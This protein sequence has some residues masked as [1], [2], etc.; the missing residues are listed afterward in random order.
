MSIRRL[1][2]QPPATSAS[3][4]TATTPAAPTATNTVKTPA[5]AARP[6]ASDQSSFTPP[7]R[8]PTELTGASA[9]QAPIPGPV[10]VNSREGQAAIQSTLA[11]ISQ[12]KSPPGA[13]LI[14]PRFDASQAFTPRSIERDE[15]GMTHVRMDRTHEGVKVF[16][17]QVIGHLDADGKFASL[18]G[19]TSSL[20]TGLGSTQPKLSEKDALAIAQKEFG[21]T[22]DQAPQVERVLYQDAKGEYQSAYRV[23]LANLGGKEQP[24]RMNYLLDANSG[25]LFESFNQL[26][27]IERPKATRTEPTAVT[28]TATPNAAIQDNK[29]VTSKIT[30]G[31][32]V[33]IDKLKLDLDIAHSY[34]GDLTVQLTSPS[35][36]TATVSDRK[37]GSADDLKGPFDLS[38]FAGEKTKGD[39]TLTVKDSAAGDTGTLKSWGLTATPKIDKPLPTPPASGTAD[40]TSLYSGKVDLSTKKN[41]DGTYSLE[42][43][44]RGQ[45]VVTLDAQG[46]DEAQNPVAIKDNNN[47]WGEAG[48]PSRNKAAV[49][50]HYGAQM[51]Y[52]MYKNVLG[53]DSLDGKGEKLVSNIH[54]GTDFVNAY[55]DGK[56]MNYGDG[57]GK[58]AGPL[59][60][61]DIAGHE[62]THG[63]TERTAGLLYRNE[64]GG[65]N[66]AFSDIMGTGVEWYAS[67]KNEAV[68]FDWAVGED[69]WTPNNGDPTDA[70]RYMDDPTKD[71]Y[72]VD[73][74]KNYPK[75]T[76]VHG[77]SGIAN[78]AFYLLANGGTNRTSKA[79]VKDGIGMEKG[80]KIYYR[81]LAHY[82]T[83]NTTFAQARE[84]TLKAATDLYG[85]NSTEAKKVAE[86][87][88]AVGVGK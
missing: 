61:L 19:E 10:N 32:D 50:A 68:K 75:Q 59:T 39:W 80:L 87:W 8:A 29:T 2:G 33:S 83:P 52:D 81:A 24:R 15:L 56:Q 65:L 31:E 28:G 79:E 69:A 22:A 45:G 77:S 66:E 42:D 48:D 40:D 51:T 11:A 47:V 3:R 4:T 72:S 46:K 84:A 82:M 13:S 18:T 78:N 54:I 70:L 12:Q 86:S 62:I 23:E 34:R 17:E 60:T 35:G 88:A 76:E 9:H 20:P 71:N 7:R 67:Q 27:G 58:D 44:T 55:W 26:G 16:G 5:A 25:K 49:D 85:A 14:G 1:D 30:L 41:A 57:N 36:K 43:S 63:L 74:Y 21:G 38:E 6:G 37:G 73:H 64:S 53:R